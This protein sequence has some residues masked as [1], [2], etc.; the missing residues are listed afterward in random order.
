VSRDDVP[1]DEPHAPDEAGT[2]GEPASAGDPGEPALTGAPDEAP[3]ESAYDLLQRGMALMHRRHNAQAAVVLE[4]AARLE[5]GKGSILESLARARFNS[6]QHDL[7]L[8]A[9][10]SLL[11]VDPTS[12]YGHYG[13]AQC[14]RKQGRERE[15]RTHLRLALAMVPG[16]ALYR[17][18]LARL[19][20]SAPTTQ[21]EPPSPGAPREPPGPPESRGHRDPEPGS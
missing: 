4:R 2:S 3:G 19:E 16:S 12:H 13:L 1:P 10:E 8:E 9:F 20:P 5:P 18:A 7:A 21:W 6:R 11:E 17:H 15:A 14:L